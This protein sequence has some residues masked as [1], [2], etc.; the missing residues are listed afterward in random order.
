MA[1]AVEYTDEFETW[2]NTLSEEEQDEVNAKVE[3]LEERRSSAGPASC[4]M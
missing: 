2:W 4:R 1:W 3:M